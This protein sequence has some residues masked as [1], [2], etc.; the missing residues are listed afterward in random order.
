M[1]R[2]LPLR[3]LRI[4][5][6]GV[7]LVVV[8]GGVIP[9]AT[10]E[11]ASDRLP[12]LRAAHVRDLRIVK[13]GSR[14]LLRFTGI[15]WNSGQGP[16][17]IRASRRTRTSS[18]W[19][20]DQIVFDTAGRTHRVQTNAAMRYAGDGHD[21]WHV[22]RMLSYHLW[23]SRGT[24]RD[25]KIGF[26]FFDTNLMDGSLPR[27]PAGPVYRE[28]MCGKRASLKTRNGISVG[29]G[30]KYPWNFAYQWIDITGLP[31]GTYTIRSAVDLYGNFV[32]RS[33]TN[34]CAWARIRFGSTGKTVKVLQRGS[35]CIDDHSTT[36]YAE[37]VAWAMS[38]GISNGCDPGIFCTNNPMTRGQ[39]AN[40]LARAMH[41]P[42]AT[43]DHFNDDDKNIHEPYINRIAEA[44]VMGACKPRK[45][46][47]DSRPRRNQVAAILANALDLPDTEED[48]FDD[49]DG[50]GYERAINRLAAAGIA[51]SCGERRYCP[52]RELTRGQMVAMLRRAF[53]TPDEPTP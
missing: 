39:V 26:C 49:D 20:I 28:S 8:L 53:E 16:F 18:A 27:S 21:H 24:L 41:L 34:N 36:A 31:G 48:F 43:S 40:F 44:G 4:A 19:D 10:V 11:A 32:E 7:G 30:D 50:S 37:D 47:P 46:C 42:V 17:E 12:D 38:A 29:W 1:A 35:G 9:P 6:L 23:G 52:S 5:A 15:M 45:F 25:S 51:V 2:R 33:D 14:R 22:R 3:P 13:S